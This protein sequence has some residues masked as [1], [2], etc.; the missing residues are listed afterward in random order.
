[1]LVYS[2]QLI[3]CACHCICVTVFLCFCRRMLQRVSSHVIASIYSFMSSFPT[4]IGL[5][6]GSDIVTE[7]LH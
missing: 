3:V 5:A 4:S 6:L 7:I 1:M 2:C